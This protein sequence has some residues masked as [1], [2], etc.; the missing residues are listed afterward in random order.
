MWKT[1]RIMYYFMMEVISLESA[2]VGKAAIR[3]AGVLRSAGVIL[4][5]TD[6]LYGLGAD[7]FSDAAVD[8]IYTIKG[9]EPQKPTH[10]IVADL[11]MAEEYAEVND[12][13]RKLAEKFMPG[14]LTLILKKK[15]GVAGGIARNID[16]IGIRI[17][18]NQFCLELARS[19]GRPFTTTSANREG[20][21]P[22]SSSGEIIMQL[23]ENASLIDL[24][25][26]GGWL[27]ESQASTIVNLVS[28]HP[29]ILREGAI[30]SAD[31]LA[32]K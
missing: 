3:A 18:N 13:A 10:C 27:P 26:D 7:A 5:P 23:G 2:G 21:M 31:I 22:A 6:T 25:I 17:P 29:S 9:R 32:F 19:F 24:V 12:A 4:Y 1:L 8:T 30:P 28:G 20:V 11:A 16:T 14:A 15:K